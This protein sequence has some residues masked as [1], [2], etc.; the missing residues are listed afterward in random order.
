[1]CSLRLYQAYDRDAGIR[2]IKDTLDVVA[3]LTDCTGKIAVPG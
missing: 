1:M 2:D 3:K